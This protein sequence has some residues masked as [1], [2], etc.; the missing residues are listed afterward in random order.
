[1]NLGSGGSFT[2]RR[3]SVDTRI[4]TAEIYG[5]DRRART[6]KRLATESLLLTAK[7]GTTITH[8]VISGVYRT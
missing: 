7:D 1:M 8:Y 4:D 2:R 3:L 6:D 5:D